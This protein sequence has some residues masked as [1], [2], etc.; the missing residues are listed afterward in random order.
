MDNSLAITVNSTEDGGAPSS[1]AGNPKTVRFQCGLLRET[2]TFAEED[3]QD[4]SLAALLEYVDEMLNVKVCMRDMLARV[5]SVKHLMEESGAGLVCVCI[6][7][8]ALFGK[9]WRRLSQTGQRE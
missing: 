8:G 4:V 2:E 1:S 9:P 7:T 6:V 5:W 3:L